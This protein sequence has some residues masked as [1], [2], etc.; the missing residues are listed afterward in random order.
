MGLARRQGAHVTAVTPGGPAEAARLQRGDVIL[1]FNGVRIEND[2]HL[3][4]VVSLTDVAK[5]VPVEIYR[6]GQVMHVNVK[7]GNKSDFPH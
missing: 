2:T 4:Y 6:A 3:I 5:E 1:R 7:V